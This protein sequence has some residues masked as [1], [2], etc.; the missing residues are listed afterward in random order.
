MQD[1]WLFEKGG[2][3]RPAICLHVR[4]TGTVHKIVWESE[5]GHYTPN[6]KCVRKEGYYDINFKNQQN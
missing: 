1:Y 4:Q 6:G 2:E 3:K 5:K